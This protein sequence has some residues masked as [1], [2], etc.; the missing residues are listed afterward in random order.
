M[1]PTVIIPPIDILQDLLYLDDKNLK[2]KLPRGNQPSGSVAGTLT[3]DGYRRLKICGAL[4][5]AHRVV[6]AM[7]HG[8]TDDYIDHINGDRSDNR[9]VNLRVATHAENKRNEK[10]RLDNQSGFIGVSWYTPTDKK[11]K[12]CWVVKVTH[13]RKVHHIGYFDKLEDAVYAYNEGCLA[14]QGSRASRKINANLSQL[15]RL[16][17]KS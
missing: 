14:L 12:H 11:K 3:K 17:E 9:I 5:L 15:E 6:W 10:L 16:K 1:K 4:C 13:L 2:W 7:H 8:P